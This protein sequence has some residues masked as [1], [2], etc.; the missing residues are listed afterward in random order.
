[1][2]EI[3]KDDNQL[4]EETMKQE[5]GLLVK[6]GIL[7]P[8]DATFY[9]KNARNLLPVWKRREYQNAEKLLKSYRDLKWAIS[10]NLSCIIKENGIPCE[11]SVLAESRV[12]RKNIDAILSEISDAV[13]LERNIIQI[14]SAAR[15]AQLSMQMLSRVEEAVEHL[16]LHYEN[17]P[18]LSDL[19]YMTFLSDEY[20]A[21]KMQ[22]NNA[23]LTIYDFLKMKKPTYYMMRKKALALFSKR[24]WRG[25]DYNFNE[26]VRFSI[27][28]EQQLKVNRNAYDL[29]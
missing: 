2:S 29:L 14:E 3:S 5:A 23:G 24:L 17:G 8:V 7:T 22:S 16:K 28:M 18:V 11:R 26:Y 21:A 25:M 15:S 27:I 1:M 19:L 4:C 12:L 6:Q 9:V 13:G 20:S 10:D